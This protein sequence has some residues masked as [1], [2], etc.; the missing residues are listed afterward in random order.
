MAQFTPLTKVSMNI[1]SDL[2]LAASDRKIS[3]EEVDFDLLGYETFY[4]RL[5]DKVWHPMY[6][7]N[8]LAQ[9]SQEEMC[10]SDFLLS[11]EYTINIRPFVPFQY[12]DLRF[13]V[14][15]SKARGLVTAVI[16]PL[17]TIPLKKGVKEWIK[18]AIHK[19]MLR[20]GFMIGMSDEELDAEIE[21]ML[22]FLQKKG[23]LSEPY[24]LIIARFF[25]E[26]SSVND[27]IILHY[28][29]SNRSKSLIQG[30]NPKELVVEYILPQQGK[31]GRGCDGVSIVVPEPKVKYEKSIKID[32]ET[33]YTVEDGRS[34][35][36]YAK[37]SG[38]V[39]LERGYLSI[40]QALSLKSLSLKKTGSID[41][42][43][44]KQITLALNQQVYRE[45]AVGTGVH[46]D[47]KKVD[48]IGTVGENTKIIADE[49]SI[50]AQTHRKSTMEVS[51]VANIKLHRGNLKAK[52]ANIE[53]LEGGRV[54]ADVVRINKMLGGEVI[55]RKV[56]VDVLYSHAKIIAL[57]SIEVNTISGE[58]NALIIDPDS[59][60]VYHE[61]IGQLKAAVEEK[62]SSHQLAKKEHSMQS[63][64]F[65][66]KNI[67]ISQFKHR[68]N[69]AKANGL[70]PMNVDVVRIKEYEVQGHK[71]HHEAGKLREDAQE[72]MG[73]KEKLSELYK[74]DL[75]GTI[76]C[77]DVYNGHNRV[78][79]VEPKT[80]REYALFPRGAVP[81]IV[82]EL[83][84]N[85]KKIRLEY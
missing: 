83:H 21:R 41:V 71:L 53:I 6:G 36:Y 64:A 10:S 29:E 8:L 58:G 14:S 77:H 27:A 45:D 50:G 60:R 69:K 1:K 7:D 22:S 46:I 28:K 84:G 56:Y 40:S 44:D 37:V 80:R 76:L 19:K 11:Q 32:E 85:E 16:S 31:N 4:K 72:I 47:V 75:Q 2:L 61:Q 79:F 63:L 18:E 82:L 20:L 59:V 74:A 3:V 13:S 66:Q 48:I 17:S 9:I 33:I 38:F 26:V 54:E 39:K 55:A 67:H 68:M 43:G 81:K 73:F 65:K 35:C 34:I 57:E 51:G 49:L 70:E 42:G 23:P 25:P 12:L 62:Q 30:V 78:A 15:M 5:P 52:E 24:N